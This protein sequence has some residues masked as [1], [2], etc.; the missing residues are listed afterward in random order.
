ML[1]FAKSV[2]GPFGVTVPAYSL[3]PGKTTEIPDRNSTN[4]ALILIA[5]WLRDF[6]VVSP[7]VGIV[8]AEDFHDYGT[9]IWAEG[10]DRILYPSAG[11]GEFSHVP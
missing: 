5:I 6:W 7:A 9:S 8:S 1:F 2:R 11:F 10:P 3:Q 4:G